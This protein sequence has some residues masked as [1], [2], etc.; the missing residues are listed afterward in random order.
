MGDTDLSE[1]TPEEN[2]TWEA[3]EVALSRELREGEALMQV[4]NQSGP[5]G[6]AFQE[7]QR[8]CVPCWEDQALPGGIAPHP[9]PTSRRTNLA[10]STA[11]QLP[12][13]AAIPAI[14]NRE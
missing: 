2:R 11:H 6:K 7:T 14:R 4:G 13:P 3:Q 5:S 10:G 1:V 9:C 12:H 8:V